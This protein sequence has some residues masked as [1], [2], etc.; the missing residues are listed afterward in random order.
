MQKG[1][2]PMIDERTEILILGSAPSEQ[3]IKK[4]EYYGNKGNQFWKIIFQVLNVP[5][6]NNYSERLRILKAHKIGLWDVY[7][8]FQRDGSMDHHFQ[9]TTLNEFETILKIAPIKQ[10]IANGKKASI[11]INRNHLF[12]SLPISH[13]AS[14][15]GANN[16][17]M[18]QR[19]EEWSN[20]LANAQQALYFG[21]DTW[22]QA[23]AFY[24]RYQV[25]V[26]EQKIP[27]QWE[28]DAI[29]QAQP[30]YFMLFEN[31][32]PIATIRYQL[33]TTPNT[34]QADRFCVAKEWRNQGIG[35][36]LLRNF[37]RQTVKEKYRYIHLSAE[38]SAVK[39]YEKQ[40]YQIASEPFLED[41]V[42]CIKMKKRSGI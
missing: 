32:E 16:G 3:S 22:I 5:D 42:S 9:Q 25:F 24:L 39:F 20:A 1:L 36:E 6:P 2:P 41:G 11:E 10:I 27:V 19:F 40:G 4:Q 34:I 37:E 17:R 21:N 35:T 28:F 38:T 30:N 12:S 15:S 13:C 29:D 14:T 26:L 18:K 33:A 31:S 23:A 8:S 7:H